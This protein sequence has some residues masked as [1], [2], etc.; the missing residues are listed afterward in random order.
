MFD[1]RL[2]LVYSGQPA[3]DSGSR[4]VL[5]EEHIM[6]VSGR[7]IGLW[8]A[9]VTVI[10]PGPAVSAHGQEPSATSGWERTLDDLERDVKALRGDDARSV[11]SASARI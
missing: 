10:C 9:V 8:L 7:P 1:N 6:Y 5:V 3:E 2:K 4:T 11:A